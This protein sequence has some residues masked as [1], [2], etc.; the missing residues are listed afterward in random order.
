ME[1]RATRVRLRVTPAA[2][3]SAIVGRHGDAWKVRVSAPADRGRANAALVEL[4][5][6]S[7]GVPRPSVCVV[8]GTSSRDKVVEL[9]GLTLAEAER[10]LAAAGKETE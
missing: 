8:A 10:R 5:A 3:Q 9:T 1:P 4:L 6:G 2:R 7:L